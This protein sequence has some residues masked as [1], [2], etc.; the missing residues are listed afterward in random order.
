ME[1]LFMGLDL[2][3]S[4]LRA[5]A[6]DGKGEVVASSSRQL[7]TDIR[8][9]GS[10]LHEQDALEWLAG[11]KTVLS[12]A[13]GEA[14][15]KRPGSEISAIS[16][17]GTSGTVVA[18]DDSITP[19]G[20]AVMYDDSRSSEHAKILADGAKEIQAKMGYS[21]SSS[22]AAPKILWLLKN[23]GPRSRARWF[24]NAADFLAV[25][26]AGGKV[27]TDMSNA[28]KMGCDLTSMSWPEEL[29]AHDVPLDRLPPIE[30]PGAI[31]CNVSEAFA[32]HCGLT[33]STR[34][35]AGVTDGTAGFLATGASSPGQMA[36]TV[37]TTLVIKLLWDELV[38]D[39]MGRIYSHVHPDGGWLPGGAS[40]SGASFLLEKFDRSRLCS[41]EGEAPADPTSLRVY[42]CAAKG[43][44]FPFRCA[45]AHGFVDGKVESDGQLYRGCLEGLAFVERLAA[46]MLEGLGV[47]VV[48]PVCSA[49]TAAEVDLLGGIRAS[50]LDRTVTL[51]REPHSAFGSAVLAASSHYG[52]VAEASGAMIKVHRKYDPEESWRVIYGEKYRQWKTCLVEKGWLENI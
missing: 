33:P 44:R 51:S 18:V 36:T 41:L 16:V 2:G 48:S 10:G 49:G 34:L 30:R 12:E 17:D 52:S 42:P 38:L 43:E 3:T 39:P 22:F 4:G 1:S 24:L 32:A 9:A 11:A 37:G 47:R 50:V 20:P 6:V 15:H 13:A 40:N 31:V 5:V 35:V 14:A 28:L 21:F 25:R 29:G 23:G 19:L 46:E 7:K 8:D 27:F 45:E 26:L